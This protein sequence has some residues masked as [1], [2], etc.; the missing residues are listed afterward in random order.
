M[1]LFIC[2]PILIFI[3]YYYLRKTR[4]ENLSI[5]DILNCTNYEVKEKIERYNKYYLKK[6]LFFLIIFALSIIL[7]VGAF[8]PKQEIFLKVEENYK[9]EKVLL[10][11][12]IEEQI[13]R[14]VSENFDD[15]SEEG[16]LIFYSELRVY[17]S[18]LSDFKKL[19]K[20]KAYLREFLGYK[21]ISKNIRLV[22]FFD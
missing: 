6:R 15:Y 1:I 19:I 14:N 4:E 12:K 18:L 7:I 5:F 8:I 16:L 13:E 20:G 22:L 2:L 11:E 17:P 3:W 21:K 9:I 10:K